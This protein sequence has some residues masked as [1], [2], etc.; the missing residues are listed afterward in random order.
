MIS[1]LYILLYY[2]WELII[3]FPFAEGH[4]PTLLDILYTMIIDD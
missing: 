2:Q 3:P 4:T 1:L